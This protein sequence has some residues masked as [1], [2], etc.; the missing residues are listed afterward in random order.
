MF[1]THFA[2][3]VA[4]AAVA[5]IL[6]A[7]VQKPTVV[8]MP[9]GITNATLTADG[10]PAVLVRGRR[11]N[12]NAH[13]FDVVSIFARAKPYQQGDVGFLL[14]PAWEGQKEI[15]ELE[16]SEGADCKLTTFR[17]FAEAG[18][19]LQLVI[20]RREFG[21][22]FA[23]TAAVTFTYFTL[24]RNTDAAPGWPPYYFEST[25]SVKAKKLYCDV[26]E[27]L[28]KELGFGGL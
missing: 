6:T 3:R 14:V 8:H 1:Y 4:L 18:R 26:D 24:K 27:A 17:L 9:Y 5:L 22:S 13:G 20:A 16:T 15:R 11:E 2:R 12:A 28:E 19:D 23:D 25:R 10:V 21:T 7:A